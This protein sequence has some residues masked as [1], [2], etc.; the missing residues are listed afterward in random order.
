MMFVSRVVYAEVPEEDR[1]DLCSQ[2]KGGDCDF[3]DVTLEE[4]GGHYIPCAD[5]MRD[6]NFVRSM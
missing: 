5:C 1:C 3:F 2:L 6:R 4:R